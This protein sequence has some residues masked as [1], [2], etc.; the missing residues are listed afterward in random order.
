MIY[1]LYFKVE[2]AIH[3]SHIYLVMQIVDLEAEPVCL[4][5]HI[6]DYFGQLRQEIK[7]KSKTF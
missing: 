4:R 3:V 6:N 2:L 7:N 5:C 1:K